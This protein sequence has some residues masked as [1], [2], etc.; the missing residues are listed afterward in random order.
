M[1]IDH[2]DEDDAPTIQRDSLAAERDPSVVDSD[3]SDDS[4]AVRA[5]YSIEYRATVEAEY[6]MAWAEA[7]PALRRAWE[8]HEKK[9][10]YPER[11]RPTVQDQDGSWRDDGGRYLDPPANAEASR[12]CAEIR[13]Q[14]EK[15]I[16]PALQR[17]EAADSER[18]LAGLEH[19]LKGEDRLKEKVADR[20]R[21]HPELSARQALTEVPDAVRF[22][23]A[24]SESRYAEGVRT[25]VE[26]LRAEGFELIKLKNS[27]TSDQYKGINSQWRKPE[28]GLRFE[29][30]FHTQA[31]FEAKQLTHKAYE[32]LRSPLTSKDEEGE[33][34]SYQRRVNSLIPHV[35]G[36]AD[37]KNYPPE[38]RDG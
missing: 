29:L 6:R 28:S 3:R 35:P 33:L 26:R 14:A 11:S 25:D 27:W 36:A 22:T 2:P 1:R 15:D 37:I 32:R 13:E 24:Y 17:I 21:Y 34:V 38:N 8:E 9:Y 23:L 10:P 30:Q 12:G 7:L 31:S 18:Q 16:L 5:A 20:L 4:E 19:W